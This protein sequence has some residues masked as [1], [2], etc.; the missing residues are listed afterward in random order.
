M[1]HPVIGLA[2]GISLERIE[3]PD[4]YAIKLRGKAV[5]SELVDQV[6][7]QIRYMLDK[8]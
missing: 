5:N 6:I 2:N 3:G 4:G 7:D 1:R 8:A